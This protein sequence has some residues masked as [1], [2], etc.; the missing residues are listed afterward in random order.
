MP[1]VCTP[2]FVVIT[3]CLISPSHLNLKVLLIAEPQPNEPMTYEAY[4]RQPEKLGGEDGTQPAPN[5]TAYSSYKPIDIRT[6]QNFDFARSCPSRP[7]IPIP[8][9]RGSS[10]SLFLQNR[11]GED[12]KISTSFN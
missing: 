10:P 12:S 4:P 2:A 9:P 11:D 3:F 5:V 7:S 8:S 6:S 1:L